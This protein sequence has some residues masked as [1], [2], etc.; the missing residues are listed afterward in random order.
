MAH[1]HGGGTSQV[2]ACM[3]TETMLLTVRC[4]GHCAPRPAGGMGQPE[5][6]ISATDSVACPSPSS[7]KRLALSLAR[8][9]A[10]FLPAPLAPAA[11]NM[12]PQACPL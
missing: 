9:E 11:T 3:A 8:I 4:G 12:H 1:W 6:G 5:L 10:G 7:S 2:H